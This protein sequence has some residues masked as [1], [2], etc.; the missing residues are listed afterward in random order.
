MLKNANLP[1]DGKVRIFDGY[2]GHPFDQKVTVGFMY[3]LK[4][5]HLVDEKS[6]P[7][8]SVRILWLR[9]SL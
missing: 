6:M 5:I 7:V 3:I 9:S 4:L 8:Q 2:S 1:E